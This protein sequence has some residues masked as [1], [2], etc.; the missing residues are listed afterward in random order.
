MMGLG[1]LRVLSYIQAYSLLLDP[2][3]GRLLSGDTMMEAHVG[4]VGDYSCITSS[5]LRG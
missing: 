4:T 2:A 1:S 5:L 3:A